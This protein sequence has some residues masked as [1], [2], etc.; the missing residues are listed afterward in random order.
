MIAT[1]K[2]TFTEE[3]AAEVLRLKPHVLSD[4]RRSG[5]ISFR[6]IVKNRVRYT[7][8]DLDEY[9]E[10]TKVSA[11]TDATVETADESRKFDS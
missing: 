10:R 8:A 2:N 1:N 6:R 11:A 3:E 9:L 5:G 7:R 4:L